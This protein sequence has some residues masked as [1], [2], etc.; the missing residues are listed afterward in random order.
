[1]KR[2][3]YKYVFL[4][5][6]VFVSA[7]VIVIFVMYRGNIGEKNIMTSITNPLVFSDTLNVSFCKNAKAAVLIDARS[8]AVLY[9]KNSKT[10]LPMASTTKIMTAICV[11]ENSSPEDVV[12]IS[13]NAS[14]T[15]GSSIYLTEG[16]SM[17]VKDLLY[18]LMLE[19]GNDAATALAEGVFGSVES[20]L[21]CMNKKAHSLGLVDTNFA[22]PHGLDDEKHYTTAYELA[23][24]TRNAMEN[25]FFRELVMTKSYV[26]A[27]KNDRYFSNHNRLL[28]SYPK[29]TGVKTGYT[30][31]AGRCLVSASCDENEEYIAVTL[32]DSLDWQDHKDMHTFAFDTFEGFEIADKDNFFV[33]GNFSKYKSPEN[34][35]ITT[36]GEGGFTLNYKIVIDKDAAFVE[37]STDS[38]SLGKF[39]LEKQYEL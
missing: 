19:S 29:A 11:I 2:R 23:L 1:M 34:I 20:C 32:D 12:I 6:A 37:Y 33:Y 22:N 28:R 35:Y 18:G 31:R 16:E 5:N 30:S 21:E 7:I 9:E 13:K 3:S 24:I 27:G 17:T 4:F 10:R 39:M 14:L 25:D 38:K 26:A 36:S 8:G 15:E